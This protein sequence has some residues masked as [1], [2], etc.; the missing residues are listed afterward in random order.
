[1][2]SLAPRSIEEGSRAIINDSAGTGLVAIS[3]RKNWR[4]P[5]SLR[6]S[7]TRLE[8][9][10]GQESPTFGRNIPAFAFLCR[11]RVARTFENAIESCL[12]LP[13]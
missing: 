5:T 7:V 10:D 1:M 13:A 11:E 12:D 3:L 9:Y 6:S 4:Y 8:G 2:I